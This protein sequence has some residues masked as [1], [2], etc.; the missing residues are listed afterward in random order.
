MIKIPVRRTLLVF[1][2]VVSFAATLCRGQTN[3]DAVWLEGESPS[4]V[5]PADFKLNVFGGPQGV[6][7]G[8]KWLQINIDADKVAA[9]FPNE[10]LTLGYTFDAAKAG[11]FDVWA[12]LGFEKIRTPFSWR[13]DGGQW[14][15]SGP[16]APTIDVQEIGVWAPVAW[17][18]LGNAPLTAGHHTLEIQLYKAKKADGKYGNLVFALDALYITSVPFHPDGPIKPG[19]TSWV[20]DADKAAA[21]RLVDVPADLGAVQTAVSLKGP[22]QYAGD[23]EIE[24]TDR[25]APTAALPDPAT[26]NWRA[27]QVPGDRNQQLPTERYVHRYYL[28][29]RINIP[30]S[31][32]GRSFVLHLPDVNMMAT[33][34]MNGKP[35]GWVKTPGAAWDCDLTAAA[36]PGKVNELVVAIKD[37]F[38]GIN[39]PDDKN[40]LPYI[41]YDFWHFSVTNSADMLVLGRY[42]T[43]LLR[44]APALVIS[45]GVYTADVFAKPSVQNKSLGLEITVHNATAQAADVSVSNEI[46]PLAG[47]PAEKTFQAKTVSVLAGQDMVLYLSE[48]WENPKLWWPDDPQQYNV[49]TRVSIAGKIVDERQTKFGFRQWTWDGPDFKLNGIPWHGFAD[50]DTNDIAKNKSHGQTMVRVWG[51]DSHTEDYLDECDAKGM[52]VRRTGIFDGEGVGGFYGLNNEALWDNYRLTEAAFIKAQRNHPS[53]FIW[54]LENEIVFI[55]GHVT[56]QDDLTTRQMKTSYAVFQQVDPTRPEMDDGGNAL[57]DESMPVY[58]G[59]YME[60]PFNTMPE[61]CYDRAGFAHRQHWPITQAK[62]IL[63]GEAAYLNGNTPAEL[64]TVGGE[65][66]SIGPAEARPAGAAILR[67]LSEGYRWNG[68]NFHFWAG[69]ELPTYYNAWS[70]TAVLCR[71][72]DWTF[73]SEQKVTR[74]LGIFNDTRSTDPITLTAVLSLD[75]KEVARDSSAHNVPPGMYEKFDV[76][77]AMPKVSARQEGVWKLTLSRSGQTVFADEKAVSVL[78]AVAATDAPLDPAVT[79]AVFDPNGGVEALLAEAGILTTHVADLAHLPATAKVLIVGKDALDAA[80]ATSSLLASWASSGRCVIVLEQTNPLKYQALPGEMAT[81][82]NAGCLGFVEDLTHPIFDGLQ[83]KDFSCWSGDGQLYRNA[84][85]KPVSGGKSL[86][87]C[88]N[89]LQDSALVQMQAGKGILLLSQLLIGQKLADCAAAQHLLLNMVKY[90]KQYQLVYRDT[91]VAAA[92]NP[93][94]TKALD[95]TGL[96]YEK[97]NDALAAIPTPGAIAVID[98]SSANLAALA[99]HADA[100]KTFTEGGGWIIFNRLTPPGLADYNK[101]VGVDHLLRKFRKEKVTWSAP[102]NPLTAGLPTANI[103]LGTGKKIMSFA[104]PEWPDENGYS[105][106]VD[107]DDIAPFGQSTYSMWNNAVNG[108]TQKDGAWQLI[109]NLPP[110]DAVMPIK[111]P[112]PEKM[113]AFTWVS[114]NNYQGTTK[115]EVEINGKKYPF[116]TLP[117]GDPQAFDL[118]DQPTTDALTVRVLDWTHDPSKLTGDKKELVGIDNIYLKVARAADFRAKVKPMLNIGALVAYPQGKGGIVLCNV[119]FQASEENP[120]NAGKKRTVIAAILGNLQARFAGGSSIIAGGDID[121]APISIASKANQFRGPQ[122]WFGDK[123]HT[124]DAL[125]AGKQTMAGAVYDIYHFTTST[126][127]E[128]I[129]LGGNGIPGKLPEAVTGIP[130]HQKADALFFLQAA[131]LTTRMND[132]DRRDGKK[133]EMADYVIHYADGSQAKAPIYAEISVDDYLQPS[134]QPIAG[135]QIAWQHAFAAEKQFAVAYSMQ[136][137]NPHPE[138]EIAEIDF[139]YGPDRRGIPALLAISAGKA[140]AGN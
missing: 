3:P 39:W 89:R 66:A 112:R 43:G 28:R 82:T 10:G 67:M 15:Q 140:H 136:W 127:P 108:F 110:A 62:P 131:H 17:L 88:D 128:A 24:V 90:A 80:S 53:I 48:A 23:D 124:F 113:L 103:V 18:H 134:P 132:R 31:L 71:Q 77:L 74:Q 107:L 59:H 114:D 8:G 41:P 122:G 119:K 84:Y 98:A 115:I 38:Y 106:V 120:E 78:P 37:A 68:I 99:A 7:S 22:W 72:W 118:P 54:S 126:V 138:K 20:S 30:A 47:G 21:Q 129:M 86:V 105:Y 111:L 2:F 76:A 36:V 50:I 29:S 109:E 51:A 95:Q 57:L 75:G 104:P 94:L 46:V 4:S 123:N 26:L 137:N 12:H 63:F 117:N 13:I 58:G 101:L 42:N 27:M 83:Q 19:D 135:A 61:S 49:I 139:V 65:E 125:P 33:V 56:G 79:V 102:R 60:S 5:V 81:D 91:H 97:A 6:L 87:Q 34:F 16:T 133:F 11:D 116:D 9:A 44:I 69:Q 35:C 40:H 70:P 1:L 92:E 55:N 14:A 100:V 25:L 32:A 121:Y 93:E 52:P 73:G 64:A 96:Q 85:V 130:V 45:G